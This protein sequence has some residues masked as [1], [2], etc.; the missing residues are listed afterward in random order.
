MRPSWQE[1]TGWCFS[2]R[3]SAPIPHA[4][5]QGFRHFQPR[6][7]LSHGQ[8]SSV[9]HSGPEQPVAGS[10]AIPSGQRQ[11]EWP[12]GVTVHWANGPQGFGIHGEV[13]GAWQAE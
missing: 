3:Q 10:P 12:S 13:G 4:P 2:T 6:H 5:G 11:S 9:L 7:D 1:Q 8:S